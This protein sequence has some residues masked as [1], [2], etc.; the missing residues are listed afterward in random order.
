MSAIAKE[1]DQNGHRENGP[2]AL[3]HA[4]DSDILTNNTGAISNQD[5]SDAGVSWLI[6]YF[7]ER[8]RSDRYANQLQQPA[9][10]PG[11]SSQVHDILNAAKNRVEDLELQL[12]QAE[13][14]W[15]YVEK[16]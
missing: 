7:E 8:R 11:S 1:T 6:G 3:E 4:T 5:P 10:K 16:T 9:A 15:C 2:P 13:V 14:S 12:D